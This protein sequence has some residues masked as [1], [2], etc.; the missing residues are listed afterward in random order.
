MHIW[1]S[2]LEKHKLQKL[3]YESTLFILMKVQ[4]YQSAMI[5]EWYII[6]SQ[7]NILSVHICMNLPEFQLIF[8]KLDEVNNTKNEKISYP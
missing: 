7:W 5:I 2:H 1:F 3:V 8:G 4:I 6:L